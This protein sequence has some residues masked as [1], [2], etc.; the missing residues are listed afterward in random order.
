MLRHRPIAA[1]P[2]CWVL[3]VTMNEA[4]VPTSGVRTPCPTY[5]EYRQGNWKGLP[6]TVGKSVRCMVFVSLE[7]F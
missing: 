7:G 1:S 2:P 5:W 4:K 3:T 6:G